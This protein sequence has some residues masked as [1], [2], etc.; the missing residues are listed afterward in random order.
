VRIEIT[1]AKIFSVVLLI[2][3]QNFFKREFGAISLLFQKSDKGLPYYIHNFVIM[4][5]I[6]NLPFSK[7]IVEKVPN[8]MKNFIWYTIEKE[9]TIQDNPIIYLSLR[10]IYKQRNSL[11]LSIDFLKFFTEWYTTKQN[12]DV[13]KA[14]SKL[15]FLIYYLL[16]IP[17]EELTTDRQKPKVEA[18]KKLYFIKYRLDDIW[19]DCFKSRYEDEERLV[20]DFVSYQK[21][22]EIKER[23]GIYYISNPW[24]DE[25]LSFK[26]E[27]EDESEL[28]KALNSLILSPRFSSIYHL[29]SNEI[30]YIFTLL[31]K[32]SPYINRDFEF[33]LEG[34]TYYCRFANTSE[35]LLIISKTFRPSGEESDTSYRN[36]LLFNMFMN[37]EFKQKSKVKEDLFA[38][39]IPISFFVKGF[40]RFEED[41][42]I[43]VSK[44]LNFFMSHYD[45][46]S[47]YILIHSTKTEKGESIKELK[48]PEMEFPKKISSGKKDP[49]LLDIAIAAHLSKQIRLKFLYYYQ[50]LEYAA[51][52]FVDSEVKQDI[53]RIITSPT[54]HANPD[55]HINDLMD[56]ITKLK[57]TEDVRLNKLIKSGC[58]IG[59]IWKE[60]QLYMPYF[61]SRQEFEGG[62]YIEPLIT[63]D[64]TQGDFSR[65]WFPKIPDTLR[66]IRNALVHSRDTRLGLVIIPSRENDPKLKPWIPIIRCVAEQTLIY[67]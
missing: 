48:L 40:D 23:K 20:K 28:I 30:E 22:N 26:I 60:I 53:L 67:C 27:K 50:I 51:F 37:P 49:I 43:E 62:F 19:R 45:K 54:I 41:K 64:M 18:S 11:P 17:F 56:I 47:P 61:S 38:N 44:H 3:F 25:S 58:S 33:I 42:I 31:D 34:K 12:K 10:A 2:L 66:K 21:F 39:R 57:E 63:K 65:E 7:E 6:E 32:K 1:P 15:N 36:L 5:F 59:E 13:E 14:L 55:K 29:D 46:E 9:L 8:G 4:L 24:D 16:E 52:Y 35:R